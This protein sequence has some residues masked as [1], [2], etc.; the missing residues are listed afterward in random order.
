MDATKELS[1]ASQN[2]DTSE[3]VYEE[4][5]K[6]M[7]RNG[8][9]T[10]N[11]VEEKE[12]SKASTSLTQSSRAGH[13]TQPARPK[14]LRFAVNPMQRKKSKRR[15]VSFYTRR[16]NRREYKHVRLIKEQI[17]RG[18]IR[19][20]WRW[21]DDN[22]CNAEAIFWDSPHILCDFDPMPLPSF[23]GYSGDQLHDFASTMAE[24]LISSNSD[25][26]DE[27]PHL[28]MKQRLVRI[29]YGIDSFVRSPP[30]RLAL[31]M[32][33]DIINIRKGNAFTQQE[34]ELELDKAARSLRRFLRR[35]FDS[36]RTHALLH[37]YL[38]QVDAEVKAFT[39][40]HLVMRFVVQ[41]ELWRRYAA[42]PE[43]DFGPVKTLAQFLPAVLLNFWRMFKLHTV[44]FPRNIQREQW[45]EAWEEWLGRYPGLDDEDEGLALP[46]LGYLVSEEEVLKEVG[47]LGGYG[48]GD[49]IM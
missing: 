4:A 35:D 9:E 16:W 30:L 28:S 44:S 3:L 17:R 49:A 46:R 13:T 42:R 39:L 40:H 22:E 1:I 14:P 24:V 37:R 27:D 29:H 12:A 32:F 5:P 41:A 47:Y 26:K 7:I 18:R 48:T 19:I 10:A 21:C 38:T 43:W 20:D 31:A 36:E 2:Q 8:K 6:T 11:G 15:W 33:V 23:I 25:G 45:D 34:L